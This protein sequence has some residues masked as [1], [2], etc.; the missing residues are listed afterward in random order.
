MNEEVFEIL[1]SQISTEISA[2]VFYTNAASLFANNCLDV[3]AKFLEKSAR[4][5]LECA[6]K[7]RKFLLANNT[8]PIIG[9]FAITSSNQDFDPLAIFED[10]LR[11]EQVVTESI[12]EIVEIALKAHDYATSSFMQFFVDKQLKSIKVISDII[13]KLKI[14]G[15]N[16]IDL[17]SPKKKK[18]ICPNEDEE[19][20]AIREGLKCIFEF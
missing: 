10:I 20:A 5:E 19:L 15:E 9:D 11:R 18:E 13:Y 17:L 2:Y 6:N 1:N 14:I 8:L 16:K 12:N 3:F 7:M 4:E